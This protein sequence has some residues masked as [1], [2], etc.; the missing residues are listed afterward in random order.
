MGI[1][2]F[3]LWIREQYP[4]ILVSIKKNNI[5][6]YIYIDINYLLHNSIYLSKNEY[7]FIKKLYNQL[8]L[9]F[10][11]FIATKKVLFALDGPGSF[12]KILLQRKRRKIISN[13]I[14]KDKINSLWLTPG[15]DTMLRIEIYLEN[16]INKI[17]NKYKFVSPIFTISK[18]TEPDEGE[19]KICK[20]IIENGNQNLNYRHLIIGNDS[21][22]IVLSMALKP[23]YNIN[24]LVR[25]KK[26]LGANE[27]IS[28][29]KL[30]KSHIVNIKINNNSIL[31][32]SNI[33]D[34]F[35]VLSIMMGNDYL[36][37]LTYIN[38]KKLWNTYFDYIRNKNESETLIKNNNYNI[39]C[40]K[41]FLYL[42]YESL[43]KTFKK[44]NILTYNF[45]K[46]K[47]YLEGILWCLNMY[48]NGKCSKYDYIYNYKSAPHP[49]ELF[50]FMCS[51]NDSI[52]IPKSNMKSLSADVYALLIM[53]Q[54]ATYLINEKYKQIMENELKYLYK[55]E[56]CNECDN[57]KKKIESLHLIL[58]N[59]KENQD[60]IKYK[61]MY[62][63]E[64]I[65]YKN[66]KKLHNEKF[67]INDIYNII[68]VVNKNNI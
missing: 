1:N 43:S 58:K 7:E 3:A 27:I 2:N 68:E 31:L 56:D 19:I 49:Y 59:N 21:D 9:I 65:I 61:K 53:P 38:Y 20:N 42:L 67:D 15:I 6:D 4:E 36:P 62:T 25:N 64:F 44:I 8:D 35:V 33:R 30:I 18:S 50:F 54:K 29:E 52:Q 5:Y 47:S 24:V 46:S 14:E 26:G 40:C 13:K 48:Q 16:Y 37:K 39:T 63:K 23:I 66:H 32:N 10:C 28:L 41:E 11:N 45:N 34:D 57:Y 55:N 12:A 17:K 22:L 60:Y 51:E